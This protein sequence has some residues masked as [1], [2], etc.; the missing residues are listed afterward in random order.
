MATDDGTSPED[1]EDYS[2]YSI[3]SGVTDLLEV[4]PRALKGYKEQI[5][6]C[7]D[8]LIKAANSIEQPDAGS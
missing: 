4:R 7:A 8:I 6:I 3:L 2:I 1:I 5:L